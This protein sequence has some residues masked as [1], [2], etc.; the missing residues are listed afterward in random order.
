[1]SMRSESQSVKANV[2]FPAKVTV[3][4]VLSLLRFNVVEDG[5]AKLERTMAVQEAVAEATCPIAVTVHAVPLLAVVVVTVDVV[6]VAVLVDVVFVVVVDVV[7]V[8]VVVDFV[9]VVA[10]VVPVDGMHWE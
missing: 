10:V 2:V 9:V 6:F 3:V 8:V 7:F 4:P 5:T 1:M